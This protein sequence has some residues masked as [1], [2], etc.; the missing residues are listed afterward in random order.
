MKIK[1]IV[2]I[3]LLMLISSCRHSDYKQKI[4]GD[5]KLVGF[6]YI[7]KDSS[8]F[9]PL[10]AG[11]CLKSGY[12]FSANDSCED[13]IGFALPFHRNA[14]FDPKTVYKL[15]EDSLMI[16]NNAN[17][18]WDGFKIKSIV[19]DT[20]LI[21]MP[22]YGFN[23][24]GYY[25]YIRQ[26]YI[27]NTTIN[28]DQVSLTNYSTWGIRDNIIVKWNGDV[29][30]QNHERYY[31]SKISKSQFQTILQRFQ[32]IDFDHLEGEYSGGGADGPEVSL[33]FIKNGKVIKTV[34]ADQGAGPLELVWAYLPISF[35]N[36]Q[37]K[38]DSAK[39]GKLDL[40]ARFFGFEDNHQYARV[41]QSML[42]YLLTILR[43]AKQTSVPFNKKY[44]VPFDYGHN[45][46]KMETD[47]QLYRITWKNGTQKTYDIGFNFIKANSGIIKFEDKKGN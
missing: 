42:F 14:V 4:L 28:F 15:D 26:H 5:W 16:L 30:Y 20:L 46:S 2:F 41:P 47:G 32:K 29:G 18:A 40:D 17:K 44:D 12:I 23:T 1:S 13:K 35:L 25:K 21:K 39:N 31:T 19:A 9:H 36:A 6:V 38:L 8:F 37:L 22:D 27:A 7:E 24:N 10:Q 11:R 3:G 33:T 34:R 45:L 43:Q